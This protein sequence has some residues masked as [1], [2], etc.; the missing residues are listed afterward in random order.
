MSFRVQVKKQKTK[1]NK[2][3]TKTHSSPRTTNY[4]IRGN[5]CALESFL[6]TVYFLMD[7]SSSS[8]FFPSWTRYGSTGFHPASIRPCR[9]YEPWSSLPKRFVGPPTPAGS[10]PPPDFLN[11]SSVPGPARQP[12]QGR[13]CPAAHPPE[14]D[15]RRRAA[16]CAAASPHGP[17]SGRRLPVP[18]PGEGQEWERK[19][20]TEED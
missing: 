2:T 5:S 1:P 8:R 4:Q 17:A 6:N 12:R 18:L 15:G 10:P 7:C 3:K 14:S 19:G 13:L 20:R 9:Q 11:P 16:P